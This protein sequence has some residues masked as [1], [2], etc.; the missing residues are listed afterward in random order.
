MHTVL[1]ASAE[2]ALVELRELAEDSLLIF[3]R[4]THSRIDYLHAEEPHRLHTEL[5]EQTD[6]PTKQSIASKCFH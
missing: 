6:R 2:L 3:V 1:T 4:E 5:F